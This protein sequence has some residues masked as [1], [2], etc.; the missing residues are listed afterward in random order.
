MN[1]KTKFSLGDRVFIIQ[2]YNKEEWVPC[3][4]CKGKG[5]VIVENNYFQYNIGFIESTMCRKLQNM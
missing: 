4:S 2:K 3:E 1:I 5:G